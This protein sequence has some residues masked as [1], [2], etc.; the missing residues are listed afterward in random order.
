MSLIYLYSYNLP[1]QVYLTNHS[2]PNY[3]RPMY[4]YN[5]SIYKNNYNVIDFVVR[6]NDRKPVALIGCELTIIIQHTASNIVVL[7]KVAKTTD[8]VNGRAQVELTADD[9]RNWS[10]GEYQYNIRISHPSGRQEFLYT[11]VNNNT[12]GVFTLYDS[13]GSSFIPATELTFEKLTNTT[14]NWDNPHPYYISG[15]I[16]ASNAVGNTDGLFSIVVY[17]DSWMGD[18]KVQGS[19]ENLSPTDKSWFDIDL[20]PGISTANFD[21]STTSPTAF[22]FCINVRWIRFIVDPKTNNTGKFIKIVYKLS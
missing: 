18:F 9:I 4:N 21:G 15:A 16:S 8:E 22:S 13:V 5:V 7:E 11:D 12:I 2:A 10:L 20:Y 14:N 17:Q 3:N 19:L 6:N 1:V